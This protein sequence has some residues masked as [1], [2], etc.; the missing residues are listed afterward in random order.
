M[1]LRKFQTS[2]INI[3]YSTP[4]G[5]TFSTARNDGMAKLNIFGR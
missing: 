5:A 3:R 4:N 2:A 1:E